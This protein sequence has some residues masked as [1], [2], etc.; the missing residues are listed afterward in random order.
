VEPNGD[1]AAEVRARIAVLQ[2]RRSTALTPTERETASTPSVEKTAGAKR[3]QRIAAGVSL[4]L[5]VIAGGSGAGAW[6][7][8]YSDYAA[9]RDQCNGQCAPGSYED[10]RSEVTRGQTAAIVLW[11]VAAAALVTGVVL[12]LVE[13]R[14][15]TAHAARAVPS[16]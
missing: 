5:A 6:G 9:R 3:P 11:S 12:L 2:Q 7:A 16:L 13:G 14:G 1:S 4:V 15:E 10:L 8:V